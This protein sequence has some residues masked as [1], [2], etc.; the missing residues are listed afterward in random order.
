MI[1]LYWF[2]ITVGFVVFFLI[3]KFYKN[4]YLDDVTTQV[5]IQSLK[6][7]NDVEP[8]DSQQCCK[9]SSPSSCTT[10]QTK[11]QDQ[12]R[13]ENG[14][15]QT[16]ASDKNEKV[17]IVYGTTTGKSELFSKQL[18]SQLIKAGC[19]TVVINASEFGS[20]IEDKMKEMKKCVFIV[21]ISTYS[22][23]T[24]PDSAK[25]F[26][27]WLSDMAG[28]FRVSHNMLQGMRHA[29]FGLGDSLYTEHYNTVARDVDNFLAQ[30]GSSRHHPLGLGDE[31]V[32]KSVTG[33][34]E[35]DFEEWKSSLLGKMSGSQV[36]ISGEEDAEV[37]EEFDSEE[38]GEDEVMDIEDLGKK[39]PTAETNGTSGPKEMVTPLLRKTLTKQGYKIIGTHSGVKLCRWTK[40]MLR[41][42]GGCYK[43][44]FYGID[45]HRYLGEV[46]QLDITFNDPG[47]W[48]PPPALRVQTSVSSAGVITQT[49]WGRNG[50]GR[51]SLPSSSSR[52]LWTTTGR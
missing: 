21:I 38:E 49:L 24:P 37:A 20:N 27:T 32:L 47:V 4:Y 8:C 13:E 44:T 41:G 46:E 35:T 14:I 40:S 2:S 39:R 9:I 7:V 43:H 10:S 26:Y 11:Q 3:K 17:V 51:W 50:D 30:L 1:E 25:W 29:V 18:E 16:A 48:R 23:G 31:N 52:A 42:R 5:K 33:S 36:K 22:E 6:V 34:L 12:K 15:D 19:D 45:S 28:D